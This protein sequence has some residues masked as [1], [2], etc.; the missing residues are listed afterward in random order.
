MGL[1][2]QLDLED[3]WVGRWVILHAERVQLPGEPSWLFRAIR[4]T[5][6]EKRQKMPALPTC[7]SWRCDMSV[8]LMAAWQQHSVPPVGHM[9]LSVLLSV[10]LFGVVFWG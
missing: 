10:Q 8:P 3:P 5:C 7:P 1:L 4:V 9:M 2:F 6:V